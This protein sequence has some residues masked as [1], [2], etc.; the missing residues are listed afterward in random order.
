MKKKISAA[1]AIFKSTTS[2]A[3]WR[4]LIFILKI[5]KKCHDFGTNCPVSV[6]LCAKFSFEMQFQGYRLEKK[7]Y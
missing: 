2:K 3:E 7:I 6:H 1:S 4:G 5:G